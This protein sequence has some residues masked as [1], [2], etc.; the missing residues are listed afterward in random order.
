[1]FLVFL[2]GGNLFTT[3]QILAMKQNLLQMKVINEAN[4]F[5]Y[6][7]FALLKVKSD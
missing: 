3:K 5:Y 7:I 2:K 1:V 6:Y 4:I